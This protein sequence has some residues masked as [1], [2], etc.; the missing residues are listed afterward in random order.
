MLLEQGNPVIIPGN[1]LYFSSPRTT[2]RAPV[3]VFGPASTRDK[4]LSDLRSRRLSKNKGMGRLQPWFVEWMDINKRF[5][6]EVTWGFGRTVKYE[7]VRATPYADYSVEINY[8]NRFIT[9]FCFYY[10]C[11]KFM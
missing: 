4:I 3:K 9:N 7:N 2:R 11:F 1:G 10:V 5:I 8:G 6:T